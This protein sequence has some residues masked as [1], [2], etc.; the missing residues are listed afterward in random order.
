[1]NIKVNSIYRSILQQLNSYIALYTAIALLINRLGRR[2]MTQ[3]NSVRYY[4]PSLLFFINDYIYFGRYW[5][6]I[7]PDC[8][9]PRLSGNPATMHVVFIS[10]FSLHDNILLSL[11]ILAHG[12]FL[13]LQIT[14]HNGKMTRANSTIPFTSSA[15]NP[16]KDK[17]YYES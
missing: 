8:V 10:I 7:V 9:L 17:I 12:L 4:S 16:D 3:Q 13:W 1:M 14:V 11:N 2:C 5:P 15:C 6:N